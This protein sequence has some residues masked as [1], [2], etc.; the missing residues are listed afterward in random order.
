MKLFDCLFCICG[1]C[2]KELWPHFYFHRIKLNF[3]DSYRKKCWFYRSLHFQ[4]IPCPL[5]FIQ[6]LSF[7][8]LPAMSR[9][10]EFQYKHSAWTKFTILKLCVLSKARF[11]II[12]CLKW[13]WIYS[14]VSP[15]FENK[16][17]VYEAT[18][19]FIYLKKI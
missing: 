1:V 18:W 4:N 15:E 9:F 8:V 6:T 7:F 10:E 13:L 16:T 14:P 17:K 3:G 5:T 2:L 11:K 19:Y 12:M